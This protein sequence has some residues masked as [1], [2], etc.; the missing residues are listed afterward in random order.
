MI[1]LLVQE[2]MY[3]SVDWVVYIPTARTVY[4]HYMKRNLFDH[5]LRHYRRRLSKPDGHSVLTSVYSSSLPYFLF[6][7]GPLAVSSSLRYISVHCSCSTKYF[8]SKIDLLPF[9]LLT[10]ITASG[11]RPVSRP[12]TG[13]LQSWS[14]W[15]SE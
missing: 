14:L 8:I 12:P 10:I 5:P 9:L 6:I 11:C 1:C 2:S 15:C 4:K 7:Y 3:H 13:C